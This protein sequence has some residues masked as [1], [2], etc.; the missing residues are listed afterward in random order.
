MQR[1]WYYSEF[2]EYDP[3]GLND[4]WSDGDA[5]YTAWAFTGGVERAP[6]LHDQPLWVTTFIFEAIAQTTISGTEL[7]LAESAGSTPTCT[8]A[9]GDWAPAHILTGEIGSALFI[10]GYPPTPTVTQWG[11]TAMTLLVLLAGTLVFRKWGQSPVS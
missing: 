5:Y 2:T 4:D 8:L 10:I 6:V 9:S 3:D 11:L 7:V 1:E